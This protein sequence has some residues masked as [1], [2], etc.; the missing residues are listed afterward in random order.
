[1]VVM[2]AGYPLNSVMKKVSLVSARILLYSKYTII[3][4]RYG[5]P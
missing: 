5:I 2:P 4:V 3:R 1:M